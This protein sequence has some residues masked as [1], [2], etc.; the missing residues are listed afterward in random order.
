MEK[1]VKFRLELPDS[2]NRLVLSA[3]AL[4]GKSKHEWLVNA[5][6]EKIE[7]DKVV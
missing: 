1:V 7:R 5:A 6:K 2:V 3:A 4:N